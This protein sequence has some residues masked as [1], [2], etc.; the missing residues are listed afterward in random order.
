[1]KVI[2]LG[3]GRMGVRH[4]QGIL[5]INSLQKV[6]IVDIRQESLDNATSALKEDASFSKCE[7]VLLEN[8][9][10]SEQYDIGIVAST[11]NGRTELFDLLVELGCK[12]IMVEKTLG[13]E[14]SR[15]V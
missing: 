9:N 12:D 10:K 2:V 6:T 7:F 13:P 4:I 5:S 8:L 3:A 11:A 14:L 1:M 15:S